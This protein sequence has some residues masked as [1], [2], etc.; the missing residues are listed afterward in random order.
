MAKRKQVPATTTQG[1]RTAPRNSRSL[2]IA[3]AGVNTSNDFRDLMSAMM[4]DVI[5][6]DI[7]TEKVNAACN[8]SRN[9]LK[10]VEL[11]YKYGGPR[12]ASAGSMALASVNR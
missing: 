1:A 5:T 3:K 7:E 9:L 4:S 6:G 12:R 11:E 2:A 10:M 8:A